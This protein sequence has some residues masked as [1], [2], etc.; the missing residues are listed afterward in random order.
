MRREGDVQ[1]VALCSDIVNGGDH[2]AVLDIDISSAILLYLFIGVK[3]HW[4]DPF[5]ACF[6]DCPKGQIKFVRKCHDFL[7]EA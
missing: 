2:L 1:L 3:R 7:A 4:M 5:V 6:G